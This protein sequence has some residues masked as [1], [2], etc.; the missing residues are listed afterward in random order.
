[1]ARFWKHFNPDATAGKRFLS[2]WQQLYPLYTKF[3]ELLKAQNL[4]Y[5]GAAYRMACDLVEAKG[6][7]CSIIEK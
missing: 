3:N 4:T 1:M 2:L 5:P 7:P 6:K